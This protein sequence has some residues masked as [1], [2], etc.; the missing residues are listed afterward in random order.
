[1]TTDELN[2]T[3]KKH[4]DKVVTRYKGKIY[5]WD[6]VNEVIEDNGKFRKSIWFKNFN[7][8]YISNAFYWTHSVDP[9]A[10]LYINDYNIES[11]NDKSDGLYSLVS[12]LLKDGIPIHGVGFQSH[13]IVGK[14]SE[15]LVKNMQRFADLGLDVAITELDIR[16]K[17]PETEDKLEQQAKDYSTVFKACQSVS[18]C[19]GVTLWGFTDKYSW[20]PQHF[21]DY[22]SALPWD[23]NYDEKP[24]VSAIEEVLKNGF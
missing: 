11:I 15:D 19:V 23:N 10:K 6:V 12:K 2:D 13:F 4:I 8:T 3:L 22:G 5:A 17:L 1:L 21:K 16:I 7:E 20:I 18:K 24:A 9:N 14:I